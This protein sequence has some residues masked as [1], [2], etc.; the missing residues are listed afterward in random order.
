MLKQILILLVVLAAVAMLAMQLGPGRGGPRVP[1]AEQET[2]E[3][4]KSNL[5]NLATAAEM[6][7][8][9]YAG[10][11]PPSTAQ[12]TPNFLRRIPTC[13]AANSDTYSPSWTVSN[14][15]P[16]A[17]TFFCSG[18]HHKG[19]WLSANYPQYNSYKGLITAR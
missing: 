18:N 8:S 15:H 12:L 3:T 7:S 6:Y 11:F 2:L 17:F 5:K 4:C 19:A 14:E 9:D 16:R 10:Q 13:P 1:Q